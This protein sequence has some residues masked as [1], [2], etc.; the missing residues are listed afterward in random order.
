MK[1]TS[2]FLR[3]DLKS[4]P[5]KPSQNSK[6]WAFLIFLVSFGLF[7]FNASAQ[8]SYTA[9]AGTETL[10]SVNGGH[11]DAEALQTQRRITGTIKDELGDPLIGATVQVVGTTTGAL[12]DTDGKFAIDV[13]NENAMLM[14]SFVGYITQQ[15]AVA[16][17]TSIDVVLSSTL[18]NLDEVVVVGYSTQKEQQ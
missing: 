16:G 17:K 12:T 13:P 7:N 3:T 1:K 14:I 15:V 8:D 5:E 4:C 11:N 9:G 10:I 18:A 6:L 2:P